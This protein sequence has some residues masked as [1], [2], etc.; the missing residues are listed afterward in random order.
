MAEHLQPP[1]LEKQPS[2]LSIN[3][4]LLTNNRALQLTD[5]HKSKIGNFRIQ[6]SGKVY[7]H[8]MKGIP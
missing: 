3:P 8:K 4:S 7:M 2:L 1:A 6:V 5:D